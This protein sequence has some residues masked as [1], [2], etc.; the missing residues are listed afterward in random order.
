MTYIFSPYASINGWT[1]AIETK[2]RLQ[3]DNY[4][5]RSSMM[6]LT[7]ASNDGRLFSFDVLPDS[8]YFDASQFK[9][10]PLIISFENVQ[11]EDQTLLEEATLYY[12]KNLAGDVSCLADRFDCYP[13][14]ASSPNFA[15]KQAY[16]QAAYQQWRE[17]KHTDITV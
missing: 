11:A 3:S 10:V 6:E 5:I 8:P 1:I 17:T 2:K 7:R 12:F 14:D 16:K 13:S 4:R 9:K 15:D